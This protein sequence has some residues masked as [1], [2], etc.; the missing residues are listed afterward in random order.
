MDANEAWS[1][2]QWAALGLQIIVFVLAIWLFFRQR[3]LPFALLMLACICHVVMHTTWFT[4]NFAAGY[5]RADPATLASV[6]S[7]AY[8]TSRSFHALFLIFIILTLVSFL[9]QRSTVAR[10]SSNQSL[11]PTAG[12]SD[13]QV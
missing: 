4:F 9:R 7:W 2:L 6:R 5:F 11:E 8:P 13:V 1:I 3:T 10:N 12:R